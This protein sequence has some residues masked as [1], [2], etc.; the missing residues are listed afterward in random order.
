M[1]TTPLSRWSAT[2]LAGL[3]QLG[4][5]VNGCGHV[6]TTKDRGQVSH[7]IE[8][9][10]PGLAGNNA[11]VYL[12]AKGAL[13]YVGM[14]LERWSEEVTSYKQVGKEP[15]LLACNAKHKALNNVM[16]HKAS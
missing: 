1:S 16:Q 12:Q 5:P 15:R 7:N 8:Y 10:W 9:G 14:P 4:Y 3:E 2:Y 11:L 13:G 6:D